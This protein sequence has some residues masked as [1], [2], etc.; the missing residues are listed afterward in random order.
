[1]LVL[2]GNWRSAYRHCPFYPLQGG[3]DAHEASPCGVKKGAFTE[4]EAQ[5][6]FDA[7]MA[8]RTKAVDATK[9]KLASEAA[10][11]AKARF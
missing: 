2:G 9:A 1:M 8:D 3:C 10:S 11:A 7:W 6:R 5:R 4:E